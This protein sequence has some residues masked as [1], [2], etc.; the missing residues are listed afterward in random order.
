MCSF[1]LLVSS[2]TWKSNWV[3]RLQDLS[4]K[5]R[6]WHDQCFNCAKCSR[7]LVEKAFA[8][9][10]D[11]LLCTECHANDYSS[12]CNNCKKTIMPGVFDD[13]NPAHWENPVLAVRGVNGRSADRESKT[14]WLVGF[15]QSDRSGQSGQRETGMWQANLLVR[16]QRLHYSPGRRQKDVVKPVKPPNKVCRKVRHWAR[17]NLAK[18]KKLHVSC[19]SFMMNMINRLEILH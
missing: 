3:I 15:R 18:R 5:D 12:K 7:S 4:Y 1:V 8:A 17:E 11:M 19:H 9:K 6:H 16:D 2:Y 13:E 10:D 14:D